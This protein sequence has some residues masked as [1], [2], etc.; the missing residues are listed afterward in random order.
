MVM[1]SLENPMIAKNILVPVDFSPLS[2]TALSYAVQL[3]K[4]L[5]ACL[6]LLHVPGDRGENL[7]AKLPVGQFAIGAGRYDQILPAKD[8]E[9]MAVGYASWI[10]APAPEIVRFAD[11]RDVDL[12]VMGTHG[13][14]GLARAHGKC[15]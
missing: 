4:A 13:R 10:G 5:G 9:A 11:V 7:E 1:S 8:A 2:E 3:A 15:G 6:Y 14:S 12:I